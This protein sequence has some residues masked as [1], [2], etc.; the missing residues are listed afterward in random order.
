MGLQARQQELWQARLEL[1]FARESAEETGVEE[2][3]DEEREA[4]DAEFIFATLP[5]TLQW[6]GTPKAARQ[7]ATPTSLPQHQTSRTRQN[8][9]TQSPALN[10]EALELK[11]SRMLKLTNERGSVPEKAAA[12]SENVHGG[13][14]VQGWASQAATDSYN[15]L[16]RK[17]AI[18]RQL[19][20]L[21]HQIQ[22][23]LKSRS[24]VV[25]SKKCPVPITEAIERAKQQVGELDEQN[26]LS[27]GFTLH[28]VPSHALLLTEARRRQWY[29]N[30]KA[31]IECRLRLRVTLKHELIRIQMQ[32]MEPP[33]AIFPPMSTATHSQ[34]RRARRKALPEEDA[35]PVGWYDEIAGPEFD[36]DYAS[37]NSMGH[38]GVAG[39]N[40]MTKAALQPLR[41]KSRAAQ[42]LRWEE[43]QNLRE[44]MHAA[45]SEHEA[46]RQSL[47]HEM[48]Q[49]EFL[50]ARTVK[51]VNEARH[52]D[53]EL[54]RKEEELMVLR[55][56]R[57]EAE[58]DLTRVSRQQLRVVML[59]WR[60]FT[61]AARPDVHEAAATHPHVKRMI[62]SQELPA[63]VRV[64]P[65]R[66][67]CKRNL[68]AMT[69]EVMERGLGGEELHAMQPWLAAC[70]KPPAFKDDSIGQGKS[71]CEG[72]ELEHVYGYRGS[73]CR[74]NVFHLRTGEAAYHAGPFG[75][76]HDLVEGPHQHRQVW[77]KDIHKGEITCAALHPD[78]ITLATAESAASVDSYP[79]ICI[80]RVMEGSC[81]LVTTLNLPLHEKVALL[82]G[83]VSSLAFSKGGR[84]VV[85][86]GDCWPSQSLVVYE[87]ESDQ[88]GALVKH[89]LDSQKALGLAVNPYTDTIVVAGDRFLNVMY[90]PDDRK[91]QYRQVV[92]HLHWDL[93]LADVRYQAVHAAS[94]H[95]VEDKM[96][97]KQG[98]DPLLFQ[99][100]RSFA[101]G[102]KRDIF[103][104]ISEQD[105]AGRD[106]LPVSYP[107]FK[108]LTEFIRKCIRSAQLGIDSRKSLCAIA[109][110]KCGLRCCEQLLELVEKGLI[111]EPG[112]AVIDS[113]AFRQD[114]LQLQTLLDSLLLEGLDAMDQHKATYHRTYVIDN[115]L[116]QSL[117]DMRNS[118][119]HLLNGS[120]PLLGD[121]F[122]RTETGLEELIQA[123]RSRYLCVEPCHAYTRLGA[124]YWK[125]NQ[126]SPV[127]HTPRMQA[128]FCIAFTGHYSY[129]TGT[130]DGSLYF[131]DGSELVGA[132]PVHS[133]A[134]IDLTVDMT[135]FEL[136]G[137]FHVITAGHDGSVRLSRCERFQQGLRDEFYSG[138]V[139]QQTH[140]VCLPISISSGIPSAAVS[141]SNIIGLDKFSGKPCL[142]WSDKPAKHAFFTMQGGI[143]YDETD[144]PTS[145]QS[146]IVGT[147]DNNLFFINFGHAE[148]CSEKTGMCQPLLQAHTAGAVACV[149]AHPRQKNLMFSGGADGVARMWDVMKR[150]LV[151]WYR[152]KDYSITCSDFSP[153][154]DVVAAGLSRGGF[155]VLDAATLLP[156]TQVVGEFQTQI[157]EEGSLH[158]CNIRCDTK[159]GLLNEADKQLLARREKLAE[160]LAKRGKLAESRDDT[161]RRPPTRS[162]KPA[163]GLKWEKIGK[164]SGK[165]REKLALQGKELSN[166]KLA[167][168]LQSRTEFTIEE[169]KTFGIK[170]L[171]KNSFIQSGDVY[172]KPAARLD[173]VQSYLD[174]QS[175]KMS[176][177]EYRD[178]CGQSL[179]VSQERDTLASD[180]AALGLKW[181]MVG[182]ARPWQGEE[183]SNLAL[184]T[185]LQS[186]REFKLEEWKAFGITDLRSDSFIQ[187][188]N[189][190]FKPADALVT[191][192]AAID[193]KVTSKLELFFKGC[194]FVPQV[195]S[196]LIKRR[197]DIEEYTLLQLAGM[198]LDKYK[199]DNLVKVTI[200]ERKQERVEIERIEYKITAEA[201]TIHFRSAASAVPQKGEITI[202]KFDDIVRHSKRKF[203]AIKFSPDSRLLAVAGMDTLFYIH[204]RGGSG[205]GDKGGGLGH[206]LIKLSG[207]TDPVRS[208]DW[209]SDS[210]HFQTNTDGHNLHFWKIIKPERS[211]W[212]AAELRART[213]CPIVSK[214]QEASMSH[215]DKEEFM[216]GFPSDLGL[217]ATGLK[218]EV[219]AEVGEQGAE[220]INSKL[221]EALTQKLEFTKDE[222]HKFKVS[223]ISGN[224]YV[225]AG[226]MVFR[227]A[228]VNWSTWTCPMGWSVLGIQTTEEFPPRNKTPVDTAL[229]KIDDPLLVFGNESGRI[230]LTRFPC[231]SVETTRKTFVGHCSPVNAVK[232]IDNFQRVASCGVGDCSIV[233]WRVVQQPEVPEVRVVVIEPDIVLHGDVSAKVEASCAV[234]LDAM[235]RGHDDAS[236]E[237]ATA[238][239]VKKARTLFAPSLLRQHDQE[240]FELLQRTQSSDSQE[241][242]I[243]AA[244][245]THK[246]DEG[247]PQLPWESSMVGPNGWGSGDYHFN[248]LGKFIRHDESEAAMPLEDAELEHVFGYQGTDR[249]CNARILQTGEL[250]YSAG[251]V[252]VITNNYTRKQRLFSR[253]QCAIVSLALH[254]D[255]CTVCSASNGFLPTILVWDGISMQVKHDLRDCFTSAG[256]ET[257]AFGGSLYDKLFVVGNDEK[258]TLTAIQ[259]DAATRLIS[260]P[261]QVTIS[262]A[263]SYRLILECLAGSTGCAQTL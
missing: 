68:S 221:A 201:L 254:P 222:W 193:K 116:Q 194:W 106:I 258:Q 22:L 84:Y 61:C 219:A 185:A 177:P 46:Q 38:P 184:A 63:H 188:G 88:C 173:Y 77:L 148:S 121:A 152:V 246:K 108:R 37:I 125:V 11:R 180:N 12:G 234:C 67:E 223:K 262:P 20:Q 57:D 16:Q 115:S 44:V 183:L 154:G 197:N 136:R 53:D 41:D 215:D 101:K 171:G 263:V 209:A 2:V 69:T 139:L 82:Q 48:T 51:S 65:E 93:L 150:E 112:E 80:W 242:E 54:Q 40:V 232:F 233:Q 98:R 124:R 72:L 189:V 153:T 203:L 261:T 172:F 158:S 92:G 251:P 26:D 259:W 182:E 6:E 85:A 47:V 58:V 174:A 66:P 7:R 56:Q 105:E 216:N 225:R 13:A 243:I 228:P 164:V 198:P 75:I 28:A 45:D 208:I 165:E 169:W 27:H 130:E 226:K 250:I 104:V 79:V 146:L 83:V 192:I 156:R 30:M 170:D 155:I 62:L 249:K 195:R 120:Y 43:E 19:R 181:E 178:L 5:R 1:G 236:E 91:E 33:E 111:H 229:K 190:Y 107:G 149:S 210:L 23:L 4:E 168:T 212:F 137:Y 95:S 220:I 187:S 49:N 25:G 99:D 204:Q 218:W 240:P 138:I 35:E 166:S 235:C 245:P 179:V 191:A 175:M 32:E 64:N 206:V 167:T 176:E 237:S 76:V 217:H 227:P 52:L 118:F 18:E 117:L 110:C 73:D 14:S 86:I 119:A 15:M 96:R 163:L 159:C 59:V 102:Y 160:S 113:I 199:A 140:K 224:S 248:P 109:E 70:F 10:P 60:A 151:L 55:R 241:D 42:L 200:D 87:W 135:G 17:A 71:F 214:E 162:K 144:V 231:P 257:I 8:T 31:V 3:Y 142:N 127:L 253:H 94:S 90:S 202:Q 230:S 255:K 131:W 123:D 213:G 89:D 100:G 157:L 78:G 211:P 256:F 252:V 238:Q 126:N 143:Q 145:K 207:H 205:G 186:R 161:E 97:E 21:K 103:G 74:S 128:I 122:R 134:I 129:I 141:L 114:V 29:L 36:Y 132:V 9:L 81:A 24:E 39:F 244:C 50:Q 247:T 260:S 239:A 133:D 147:S 34:K 196:E